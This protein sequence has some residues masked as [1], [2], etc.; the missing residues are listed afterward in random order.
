LVV[1]F[2]WPS[3]MATVFADSIVLNVLLAELF[4]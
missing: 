4:L 2:T 3:I 1:L